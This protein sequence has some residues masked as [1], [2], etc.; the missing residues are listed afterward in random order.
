MAYSP[1]DPQASGV[2]PQVLQLTK[3]LLACVKVSKK[4][5]FKLESNLLQLDLVFGGLCL[6][7]ALSFATPAHMLALND[8]SRNRY[9]LGSK[10][11]FRML[12]IVII[13][14]R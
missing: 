6:L 8:T 13:D 2:S 14:L 12:V 7:F 11:S 1:V 10:T 5:S 9:S 3:Y 4:D